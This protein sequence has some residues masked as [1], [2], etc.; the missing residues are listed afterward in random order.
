[1]SLVFLHAT[2]IQEVWYQ[3]ESS[4]ANFRSRTRFMTTCPSL[5]T[6]ILL[7][8]MLI[9]ISKMSVIYFFCINESIKFTSLWLAEKPSYLLTI[10]F[11]YSVMNKLYTR[12]ESSII[13][14]FDSTI[15]LCVDGE[16]CLHS[17]VCM[18]ALNEIKSAAVV[19]VKKEIE[20]L[21][22]AQNERAKQTQTE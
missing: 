15:W 4:T 20:K 8:I 1:M 14:A 17:T 7:L 2:K 9:H 3:G 11:I 21:V 18:I 13:V 6:R 16:I 5:Q 22:E 12:Q 19:I 10:M